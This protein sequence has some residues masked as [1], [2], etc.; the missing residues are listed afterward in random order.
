MLEVGVGEGMPGGVGGGA[1][2][3]EANTPADID[4]LE[5]AAS[6]AQ[7][8]ALK[9]EGKVDQVAPAV[10]NVVPQTTTG[11]AKQGENTGTTQ[12]IEEK[13]PTESPIIPEKVA[14]DP[15]YKEIWGGLFVQA[16]AGGKKVDIP[17]L[18]EQALSDYY[19]KSAE[20]QL[21]DGLPQ[22]IKDDPDYQQKL[23]EAMTNAQKN[24]ESLDGS[25][26]SQEALAKYLQEK[27][28]K[29][30]TD[31]G[32]QEVSDK[33]G[34]ILKNNKEAIET[35]MVTVPAKDLVLLLQALAEAKEP[36]PR[37][38]ETKLKLLMRIL[39]ILAFSI[40][41]EAGKTVVPPTG[42]R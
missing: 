38:K 40:V 41:T 14:N 25:K 6:E 4:N 31:Q 21:K 12:E 20:V 16:G 33:I 39:G 34:D 35:A 11:S 15:K 1:P 9:Q 36:D 32:L 22:E 30:E 23:G 2:P 19:N 10:D 24:G 26:L 37:K 18:D 5:N 17:A 7:K 13:L 8:D 28:F 27:D 29:S 42:Q 3:I